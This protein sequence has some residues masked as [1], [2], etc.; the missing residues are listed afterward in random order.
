MNTPWRRHHPYGLAATVL[1]VL[2]V[3]GLTFALSHVATACALCLAGR[4]LTIS[5]QELV[6]AGRSVLAV[7]DVGGKTFRVVEVIKGEHPPGDT[8][9]DTVFRADST[10]MRSTK[11]A[12]AHPRRCLAMVGQFRPDCGR[13]SR[14]AAAVG[15][16]QE[17]DRD[18]CRRMA[19]SRR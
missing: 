10:A 16:H 18:E 8:I 15:G 3:G 12:A 19:R 2:L 7:P 11:A 1:L 4:T 9:T 5:A 13:T 6:Y 14:L 17:D